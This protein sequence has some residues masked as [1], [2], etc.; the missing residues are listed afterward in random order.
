MKLRLLSDK[1]SVPNP[2]EILKVGAHLMWEQQDDCNDAPSFDEQIMD[3]CLSFS[4]ASKLWHDCPTIH[5]SRQFL[6]LYLPYSLPDEFVEV[7]RGTDLYV[8]EEDVAV[9]HHLQGQNI[10]CVYWLSEFYNKRRGSKALLCSRKYLVQSILCSAPLSFV[11]FIYTDSGF[12]MCLGSE[13]YEN[14]KDFLYEAWAKAEQ[15][16]LNLGANKRFSL[17]TV[18]GVLGM[19]SNAS[20][21]FFADRYNK[22]MAHVDYDKWFNLLK[23]W[24]KTYAKT[25]CRRVLELACGTAA[26]ASRF[27]QNGCEVFASDISAQMLENASKRPLKPFLYQASLTDPI[28]YLELDLI[29][30]LFD[31]INYLS[32]LQEIKICFDV[33]EK[34]LSSDGLFIFDISTLLNSIENFSDNCNLS[35]EKEGMMIHEAY[36]E[37]GKRK[38][39]SR[40]ELFQEWGAAYIHQSETH[41]QRVYLVSEIMDIVNSSNLSLKAIHSVENKGNLYPKKLQGLDHRYYRLFFVL[42]KK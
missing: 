14:R 10:N 28:P 34:A 23:L 3:I 6:L 15:V 12:Q 30:C 4:L 13:L 40:L 37:P 32:S 2:S 9:K 20:Y 18:Q 1:L 35:R 5:V 31:S 22:Y 19:Q 8:F 17:F 24:H 42:S 27:V 21:T 11:H 41:V 33:V 39:I 26:V 16:C 7:L 29:F 25:P 36:Y 38:Q